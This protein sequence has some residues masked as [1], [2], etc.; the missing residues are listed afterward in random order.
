MPQVTLRLSS[1]WKGEEEYL[2]EKQTP[3]KAPLLWHLKLGLNGCFISEITGDLS[4][5]AGIWYAVQGPSR[6]A[7][8]PSASSL[9]AAMCTHTHTLYFSQPVNVLVPHALSS[10]TV[11]LHFPQHN[12]TQHGGNTDLPGYVSVFRVAQFRLSTDQ[13]CCKAL[14][15]CREMRLAPRMSR[16]TISC[17][18]MMQFPIKRCLTKQ[19]AM[20][21][22]VG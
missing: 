15:M 9:S 17:L 10:P 3:A 21:L 14:W 5:Q 6:T 22:K 1:H 20:Q 4:E 13:L 8:A 19:G 16:V 11:C 2:S 12:P 18:W 7:S